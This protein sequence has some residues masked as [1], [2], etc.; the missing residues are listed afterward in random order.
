MHLIGSIPCRIWIQINPLKNSTTDLNTTWFHPG[1]DPF[2]TLVSTL[3]FHICFHRVGQS[4]H[5]ISYMPKFRKVL[6]W[7]HFY[8][9]PIVVV[10]WLAITECF[11]LFFNGNQNLLKKH[12]GIKVK[13]WKANTENHSKKGKE[14][15]NKN[16]SN[17]E[18]FSGTVCTCFYWE[19]QVQFFNII[20]YLTMSSLDQKNQHNRFNINQNNWTLP[21][22]LQLHYKASSPNRTPFLQ[23]P[24]LYC[25]LQ[26]Q[27]QYF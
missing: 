6:H 2:E 9:N 27:S 16:K 3:V 14:H 11:F 4:S 26:H 15:N 17:N 24:Y 7:Y 23:N 20:N 12:T 21:Q 1:P 18:V 5:A 10:I 25:K 8:I 22:Y 19:T 13:Y